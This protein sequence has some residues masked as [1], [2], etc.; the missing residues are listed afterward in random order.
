[1]L[2][3]KN[4]L[5]PTRYPKSFF[6]VEKARVCAIIPTYKPG[7]IT[8]RLIKDLVRWNPNIWVYVVDDCTPQGH[9]ESDQMFERIA[10][11]SPKVMLLRTP[12]NSLKA[13]ALNCGLAYLFREHGYE[14]DAI[15]TLDDDVAITP[16]TVRTLVIELM[17]QD[18]LGAV[19]S[20]CHVLNKNKNL[21]TRLQSLEYHG[22]NATRLA[23]EG[24]F[25]G[26]LVMHGMLTA[27]RAKAL[28]EVGNFAE[29]HL[30]EDYEITARL[31]AKGW[32][33]KSAPNSHAWTQV[34]ECFSTLWR[35]RARWSYGG[36]TVVDGTRQ[37]T[38][39]LQDLIGHGMFWAT[40]FT[41][42]ILVVSIVLKS[43]GGISPQ[44]PYWII[45]LSFMQ[46]VIWYVFQLWLMKLYRERDVYDWIIRVSVIPEFVYANI[47]T[48]VL[49]GSYCFLF[50]NTLARSAKKRGRVGVHGLVS[51][52]RE[53]FR[54]CGYTKSWG[55]RS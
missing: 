21:L 43:G 36:I 10:A 33:V 7:K 35:Q 14:L 52:S 40:V 12:A 32:S 47:L 51:S 3:F 4:F 17:A 20:Q 54:A 55:T 30:I 42:N 44:I 53:L 48:L 39:V 27:F 8:E 25:G 34:P 23:D 16:S 11:C 38:S 22:F 6:D 24:F 31:K 19:C 29:R 50:F 18:N 45:A 1:M 13:G 5:V 15:L 37:L 46:F 28:R 41:I 9:G 49:V 2:D 26:P